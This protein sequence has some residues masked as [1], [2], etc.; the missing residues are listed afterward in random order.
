MY[1][2]LIAPVLYP[3]RT[4]DVTQH[5]F[6]LRTLAKPFDNSK[7]DLS[8]YYKYDQEDM[9]NGSVTFFDNLETKTYGGSLFYDHNESEFLELKFGINY[10]KN[11]TIGIKEDSVSSSS[12][13]SYD[14][15]SAY[16]LLRANIFDKIIQPSIFYKYDIIYWQKEYEEGNSGFGGDIRIVP[17]NN[18]SFYLGY[19]RATQFEAK[20][21]ETF[22][23]GGKLEVDD[24]L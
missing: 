14:Y 15:F 7:L 24:F 23:I 20:D 3:N 19:S 1:E 2:P 6:T 17:Q 9:K 10:D 16:G 13:F 4:L 18:Y 22:E 21:V 11:N 5:N 8:L 12:E